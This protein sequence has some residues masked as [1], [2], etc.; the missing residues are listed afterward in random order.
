MMRG[1]ARG[2]FHQRLGGRRC[3]CSGDLGGQARALTN[4]GSESVDD[5]NKDP[6]QAV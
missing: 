3:G 5:S 2:S 1:C 6:S 4:K